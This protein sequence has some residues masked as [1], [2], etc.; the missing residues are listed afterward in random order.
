MM[1]VPQAAA[2]AQPPAVPF[3]E[4]QHTHFPYNSSGHGLIHYLGQP[5]DGADQWK[6]PSVQ[7]VVGV[8]V[9]CL[10][11]GNISAFVERPSGGDDSHARLVT[12]GDFPYPWVEVE[13][14]VAVHASAYQLSHGGPAKILHARNWSLLGSNDG[15]E[16]KVLAH[17]QNDY[18]IRVDENTFALRGAWALSVPREERNFFCFFRIVGLPDPFTNS[19]R[20]R[21]GANPSHA[22]AVSCFEVFGEV[23]PRQ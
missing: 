9:S 17:H 3:V 8:R 6:N 16:W 23:R 14:P 2:A 13:L 11:E 22:L 12:S 20:G 1:Q 7:G 5:S 21:H 19:G 15:R 10:A 4:I 18:Q